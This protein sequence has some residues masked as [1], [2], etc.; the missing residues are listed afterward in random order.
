MLFFNLRYDCLDA[1]DDFASQRAYD[2]DTNNSNPYSQE[3]SDNLD[4]LMREKQNVFNDDPYVDSDRSRLHE[5]L[6]FPRM[7][8][9]GVTPHKESEGEDGVCCID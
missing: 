5:T 9:S 3:M 6:P 7:A 4:Q 2:Q 1:C 8:K